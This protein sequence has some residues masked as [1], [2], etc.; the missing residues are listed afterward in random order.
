MTLSE[1]NKIYLIYGSISI[2]IIAVIIWFSLY[3]MSKG[4]GF[5]NRLVD[6]GATRKSAI[7]MFIDRQDSPP[8]THGVAKGMD[9]LLKKTKKEGAFFP[10][11]MG[12]E[13]GHGPFAP[14]RAIGY[15]KD[16]MLAKR[17]KKETMKDRSA[18]KAFTPSPKLM[19]G[20]TKIDPIRLNV[21]F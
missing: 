15:K 14:T 7:P 19:E 1:Q 11:D 20:I 5:M 8:F 9:I 10:E 2:A 12:I 17:P 4:E 21:K 6:R 13:Y 16:P 3:Y 18:I